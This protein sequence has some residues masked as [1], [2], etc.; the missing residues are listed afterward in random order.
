MD[1]FDEQFERELESM[2]DDGSI[3]DI[4]EE[5]LI[6]FD[7]AKLEILHPGLYELVW[8]D[9]QRDI[10]ESI[11]SLMDKGLL[12]MSFQQTENGGL[13]EVFMLTEEGRRVAEEMGGFPPLDT[14]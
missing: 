5:G 9:I 8:E 14:P 6:K 2:K 4:N 13:E 11:R 10:D 7:L 12:Q 3:I 1:D